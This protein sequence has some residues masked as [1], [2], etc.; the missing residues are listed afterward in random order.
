MDGGRRRRRRSAAEMVPNTRR[1]AWYTWW[2][3]VRFAAHFGG[4][5]RFEPVRFVAG[6]SPGGR[7]PTTLPEVARRTVG[8]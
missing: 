8:A 1:A 2:R 4:W 5:E 7:T 3:S 6:R